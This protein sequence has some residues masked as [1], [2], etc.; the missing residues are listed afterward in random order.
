M[1]PT[2]QDPVDPCV[3]YPAPPS[4]RQRRH[5]ITTCSLA[6]LAAAATAVWLL[7]PPTVTYTTALATQASTP[8]TL[9]IPTQA[10]LYAPQTTG[11]GDIGL[12]PHVWILRNRKPVPVAVTLG[13]EQGGQVEIT[14]APL[15][16][17]DPIVVAE[18]TAKTRE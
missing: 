5:I 14:A 6:V 18:R 3:D 17:G 12:S 10:L 9:L 8:N 15:N 2:I 7:S 11:T 13:P 4:R 1:T 16:A